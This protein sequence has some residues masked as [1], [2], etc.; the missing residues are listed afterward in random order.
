MREREFLQ[1]QHFGCLLDGGVS[2]QS[3]P[4]VLPVHTV[5]KE[6]L[7]SCAAFTLTYQAQPV[8]I[9]RTPEFYKHQKEERCCRQ[10]GTYNPNH[11]YVKASGSYCVY[12]DNDNNI[13]SSSSSSVSNRGNSVWLIRWC[14]P[15]WMVIV[16][17]SW[18]LSLAGFWFLCDHEY[19][20]HKVRSRPQKFRLQF[21]SMLRTKCTI[22]V[23]V[24]TYCRT[25][26][27]VG[28]A[29]VKAH[30]NSIINSFSIWNKSKEPVQS[31]HWHASQI[32]IP[33][34]IYEQWTTSSSSLVY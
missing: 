4:I 1:S 18:P 27:R 9:L 8:A 13:S 12:D 25:V 5:D 6:R 11:P 15:W 2:N 17:S 16:L 19:F 30:V 33:C 31:G 21:L 3:I 14:P 23:E 10:F 7:E 22:T 20:Q 32:T 26:E 24:K 29:V 28:L 34:S